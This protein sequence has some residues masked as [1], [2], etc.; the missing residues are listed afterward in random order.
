MKPYTLIAV[1]LLALIAFG[2]ILRV[3]LGWSIIAE[4][5]VIPMWPSVLVVILFGGL[6]AMVWREASERH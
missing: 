3:L 2:H 1:V 6:A 5:V 4:G